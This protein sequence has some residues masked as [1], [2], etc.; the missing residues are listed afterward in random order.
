MKPYKSIALALAVVPSL[1]F[2]S[3]V[4]AR[5]TFTVRCLAFQ[6]GFPGELHAHDAGGNS[7]AGQVEIKSYLNHETNVLKPESDQLVFTQ[8]MR[9]ASAT[10]VNEVVGQ[11]KI[12]TN[13]KSAIL[14]FLPEN[15]EPDKPKC[16]VQAVD[17]NAKDFPAGSFKVTNFTDSEVKIVLDGNE[18]LIPA[19]ESKVI[20]KLKYNDQE[21]IGMSAYSKKGEEWETITTGSW[22]NPGARRI[23]EVLYKDPKRGKVMLKGVIDTPTK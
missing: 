11:F 2:A 23:L 12:P 16:Q 17:D 8:V 20:S 1:L 10:D 9:P 19:G 7:T 18:N 6:P 4:T 14:V 3:R 22:T 21:S 5:E 15:S 13:L